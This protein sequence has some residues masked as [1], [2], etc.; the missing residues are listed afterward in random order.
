MNKSI[1]Q[2]YV[3]LGMR[4][5]DPYGMRFHPIDKKWKMHYG[6]DLAGVPGGWPIP[7]QYAG[8]I[9][10]VGFHRIYGEVVTVASAQRAVV[11]MYCHLRSGTIR[12]KVGQKIKA[13]DILGGVGSTGYSTGNHLHLEIRKDN[14]SSFGSPVWGD[15]ATYFEKIEEVSKL[16]EI[17]ATV[18]I[19]DQENSIHTFEGYGIRP[20][21]GK[22]SKTFVELRKFLEYCGGRLGTNNYPHSVGFIRP[23]LQ[24]D[25]S[26]DP[27]VARSVQ[28]VLDAEAAYKQAVEELR[29]LVK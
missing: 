24:N 14:G 16:P 10:W 13:G 21:P 4:I 23:V 22:S 9:R 5:T 26:C 15:P 27:A 18:V 28:A 12:V 6:T 19:V 25:G 29:A 20:E 17:T 1:V 11:L 7:A 8:V 3:D 2:R